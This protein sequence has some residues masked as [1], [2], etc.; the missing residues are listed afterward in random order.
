MNTRIIYTQQASL[1]LTAR[2][3]KK[4]PLPAVQR[5]RNLKKWREKHSIFL[6]RILRLV[7]RDIYVTNGGVRFAL[8]LF[9]RLWILSVR[10]FSSI[11]HV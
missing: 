5:K 10:V 6:P 7:V 4:K 11:N 8:W 1:R 2:K 3:L 9:V